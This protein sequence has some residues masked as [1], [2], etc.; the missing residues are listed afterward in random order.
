MKRTAALAMLKEFEELERGHYSITAEDA[1]W[2]EENIPGVPGE[3]LEFMKGQSWCLAG[4]DLPWNRRQRRMH[5]TSKGIIVHLFSGTNVKRWKD[6]LPSGYTW[7]FVDPLLG[8][9][10]DLHS[11]QAVSYTHLTLP[12]KLEV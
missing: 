9:R 5:Q 1:Q 10:Y 6:S 2:W 11:P 7:L 8:S 12:T 4:D 3:L